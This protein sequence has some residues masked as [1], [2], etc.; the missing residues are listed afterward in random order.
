MEML[1]IRM[2]DEY[3]MLRAIELAKRGKGKTNPNPIVGAVIVKKNK[4]IGEGWHKRYGEPHAERNAFASLMESA[5][6]ATLYVTLEPCCH[7]G[8]TPPCTEAIIKNKIKRVVIGSSDPNPLVAG[9]GVNIL[10]EH[11]II[12]EDNFLKDKC[13]ELNEIFFHYIINK[14]PYVVMKYAMTADGKIAT[15]IG[16]SKWITC[17]ESRKEVHKLRSEYMGIMVG[18]G[19]VE[20]DNPMLNCRIENLRNPIR[21][22]CDSNLKINLE[23][24]ICKTAQKYETYIVCAKKDLPDGIIEKSSIEKIE[25][26]I[27]LGLKIINAPQSDNEPKVNLSKLMKILGEIGIDSILL[28]GG[29]TLNASALKEGI[30]NEIRAF[31][32]PKLFGEDGKSP[33]GKMGIDIPDDAVKLK[34]ISTEIFG[35]DVMLR[36]KF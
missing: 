29:G 35:E 20:K 18:I 1:I 31:V 28:E 32:A 8:K 7:F 25:N 17:E 2:N 11:G 5:E 36:M 19:T 30:V 9:K 14:T 33:I 4:I 3:Y 26:L 10:R 34:I 6:N 15:H 24:N 27:K 13:D 23:S 16:K 21:I 22:V 12:V